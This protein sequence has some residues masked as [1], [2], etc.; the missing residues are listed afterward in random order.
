ME[1]MQKNYSFAPPASEGEQ[2]RVRKIYNGEDLLDCPG[3]CPTLFG[4][5]VARKL[6]SKEELM[7]NIMSPGKDLEFMPSPRVPMTPTRKALFR[8]WIVFDVY[9]SDNSIYIDTKFR[10]IRS[11]IGDF[12]TCYLFRVC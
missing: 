11:S 6:W 5:N 2:G 8:G 9:D 7:N 3:D 12:L 10:L 1:W 4:R